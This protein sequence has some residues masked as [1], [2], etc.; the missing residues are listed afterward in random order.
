M[1]LVRP[2]DFA[3]LPALERLAKQAGIG[4]TNLPANR[5]RLNDKIAT[6]KRS[7]QADIIQPGD[8]SYLFVL[9][10]TRHNK[11]V[12]CCGIDAMVGTDAPFYSYRIDEVVHASPQLQIH[13][14]IPAL[15][16]CHDYNGTSRLIALVVDK[17]HQNTL[18]VSLLS[19]A[20]LL[21]IARY[22]Q[23]FTKRLFAELRGES[24]KQGHSP[25][26]DALGKHFFSM[27]FK[28]AD[29]L[30]G[31]SNKHFIADLMPRYPIYVPTLPENAQETIGVIHEDSSQSADILLNEGFE[32][33]GYVDIFDA[34]PSVEAQTH[35]L[36]TI[37]NQQTG[38]A[39]SINP[40]QQAKQYLIA[41]GHLE[42]FHVTVSTAEPQS[43]GLGVDHATLEQLDIKV[44]SRIQWSAL[45]LATDK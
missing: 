4:F 44:G 15:F 3:D 20:R 36:H 19:K 17:A 30:S 31:V 32:F 7:L 24:D 33:R 2:A 39:L 42:H 12:G 6:S 8:E 41:T 26:W 25:F 27:D 28:K 14:R 16:L 29:Y 21:F 34:G 45:S 18:A 23:R 43:A 5:E 22:P 1:Y 35:S 11:V 37:V 13:N 40:T 38:K 10:D 9:M